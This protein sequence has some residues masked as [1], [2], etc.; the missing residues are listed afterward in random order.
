MNTKIILTG[1]IYAIAKKQFDEQETVYAQ[2]LNKQ[3][4]GGVEIQQVKMIDSI[5]IANLKEG[6]N[7][8]IPVKI[9]SYQNKIFF[10]QVEPSLK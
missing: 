2:F 4:N 1:T 9:S 5:D 8:K 7:I 10:T 3:E 6:Q